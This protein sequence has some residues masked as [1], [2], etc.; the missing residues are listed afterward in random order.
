MVQVNTHL[1][2]GVP[3][4]DRALRGLIA[5]DNIVWHVDTVADYLPFVDPYCASACGSGRRLIY[6]RFG[7]HAPLVADDDAAETHQ[8]D[9]RMGFEAFITHVHQVI[10][11]SEREAWY[12]FDCLSD[13]AKAWRSDSML[14]NFFVLTCPYLY[15]VGAIA[16]FGLLRRTHEAETVERIKSTAQVFLDAYRHRGEVYVHPVKVQQ[17]HSPTMYM[18]HVWRGENFLPVADSAT[19]AEV[20]STALWQPTE[21][22]RKSQ[23]VWYEAFESAERTLAA[24]RRCEISPEEAK[25]AL[26]HLLL[27]AITRDQRMLELAEQYLSIEDLL[28]V[29]RRIIG[30]GL[31]GGKAIGMLLARSILRRS[32]PRWSSMLEIHDSF[33]IGSDVFYTFLVQN[34]LWWE[35][36]S[37]RDLEF[38][39]RDPQQ[40]YKAA[41][42]A[43]RRILVGAFREHIQTQFQSMLDYF[44]QSP[45]IVRSSSLLE[46]TFTQ[47]FAGKYESVF[48]ANQG[49]RDQ[50]LH[51]FLSAVRTIYAS[52]MSEAALSYR[53]RWGLLAGDEQMA[54]LVQR[55]SGAVHDRL[56][57]PHLAGVGFSYNPYVWSKEID[58]RAGVLRLVFGLGTRAVDRPEDDYARVVALNAP[59]RRPVAGYQDVVQYSQHRVDVI[60]LEANQ[61]VTRDFEDVAGQ[62]G[63]VPIELFASADETAGYQPQG[64]AASRRVL[65]FD[66]LLQDTDYVPTM[67]RM[68]ESLETCYGA[69]VDVE[70]TANFTSRDHYRLNV[71]QCRPLV[72]KRLDPIDNPPAKIRPE[73][74]LLKAHGAVIGHSRICAVQRI[75]YVVPSVYGQMP[76]RERYAVARL[77]GKL[78][79]HEHSTE[80][81]T[82]MLVGPGRW[83]TST[84]SRGVPVNFSEIS[85]IVAIGELV[86]M[87]DGLVPDVSLGTHFFNELVEADIL[88]FALFPDRDGNQINCELL[89]GA[90]NRLAELMPDE[91]RWAHAVRVLDSPLNGDGCPLVLNANTLEQT[92]VCYR[93]PAEE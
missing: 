67:R 80:L 44:G 59:D 18:L 53:A 29:A 79:R 15:D 90:E 77:I 71:V 62:S 46:D 61:L 16:Y 52:T 40:F 37:H 8:F 84:P 57:Y 14:G 64:H 92:V 30:T 78:V 76:L 66:G 86:V 63:K 2:T 93:Q 42:H 31:I 73:N 28:E 17:R 70:F 3:G 91:S 89:E 43:R 58:P 27:T 10:Q 75:I 56:F 50:R 54:L 1:S 9:P 21:L 36:Q 24:L 72:V 32:D 74:L 60:D 22:G 33:Y 13:L 88:Y 41:E 38:F 20:V 34:G 49:S 82:T 6:F 81:L 85:R 35:S 25:P 48:L 23:G 26:R 5:G 39:E 47:S 7:D 4:L 65:A 11:R 68:L 55:V 45:I 19:T 12:V 69:P 83:G 51:D 87:R